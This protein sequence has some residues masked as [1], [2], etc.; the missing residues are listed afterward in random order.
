MNIVFRTDASL[1][2]GTGHVIRCL[3]LA[4]ALREAGGSCRFIC[5][6]HEGNLIA[7]I[8]EEKFE[9]SKLNNTDHTPMAHVGI[10]SDQDYE[11]WLGAS[12]QVDATQTI[13]AIGN[14]KVD[15]LVV[16]HYGID[17][18][19]EGA[20][21]PYVSK[22][23]VVDDLANRH[24]DCD[25]LLDQNLVGNFQSRYDSLV[26]SRCIRLLGPE[27]ALLQPEYSKLRSVAAPRTGPVKR[28]LI[29]FG[30]ADR[31]NL[32]RLSISAFL[33]LDLSDIE[34]DVVVSSDSPQA[35][36]ILHYASLHPN[37]H[38]HHSLPTLAHL[39]LKADLA[40]GAAGST[41]WERCCLG[42]PSIVVALAANQKPVAEELQRRELALCPGDRS[43][44][45]ELNLID[46]L[47]SVM[48]WPSLE[49]WSRKCHDV[50]DGSGTTKVSAVLMLNFETPLVA[51]P[52]ELADE[53][54]LFDLAN[55]SLV[56][57]NSFSSDLISV[58]TH[59]DWF[60]RC[61]REPERS[62]ILIV[63]TKNRL[64]IGQVRFE[65]V[66]MSC[67]EVHYSL[68]AYAR[69]LGLARPML[70]A[71]LS[72]MV[73]LVSIETI[74]AKVKEDNAASIRVFAKLG[75]LQETLSDH[76]VFTKSIH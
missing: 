56:R 68:V 38:I 58:K 45:T 6:E 11:S 48:E 36:Q 31:A 46:A 25:V 57:K 18:R 67:W 49:Q 73:D 1:Q 4:R 2:T 64:R 55:D 20:L 43:K 50:T 13:K 53:V 52:S 33:K 19:W 54:F 61:L 76:I 15:V 70:L 8:L 47:V 27:F 41:S 34:L 65:L 51:R 12:W 26:P 69:R 30:G 63:E 40:I 75:F 7:R 14:E 66:R 71:A 10:V 22:I 24:H 21:R 16:D 32:T 44:I 74:I 62:Q 39:M 3:T 29:F 23:M 60:Y 59:K 35:S 28:I 72:S 17:Q 9:V 5:R 37:I 42:L